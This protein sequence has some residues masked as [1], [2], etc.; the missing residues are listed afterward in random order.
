MLDSDG[1][2]LDEVGPWAKEKHE[3]L[4][5]YVDIS[6][7]V[8][9]KFLAGS[10]TATYVDLYCGSG[11]AIVR[12]SDERIDGSPLVA[13]KSAQEGGAPFSEIHIADESEERCQA[14]QRRIASAGG[15]A[16]AE[17]GTADATSHQIAKKLS[18]YGLHFVFLDPYNL[19][20]LPFSVIEAFSGF[21][22][23]DMLIH[24]SVQDLQRNLDAYSASERGPLDRFAPDW[25]E[26]VD[27]KQTQ[28]A[29]RASLI[30]YWISKIESL[31]LSVSQNAQLVTGPIRH[32]RLYWL[33][34]VGRHP[35]ANEFWDKI[36]NVSGQGELL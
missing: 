36:R 16:K 1:L 11:R 5:R 27:L 17:V 28:V 23:I 25:R 12:E 3:R 18:P 6:R 20:D 2:P 34:F 31:G 15:A 9:R 22:Y 10:G 4:R 35:L 29:T 24:V 19:N 33:V 32:Q 7:A 8:R 26:V 14:A 30:S 13:F 21:K